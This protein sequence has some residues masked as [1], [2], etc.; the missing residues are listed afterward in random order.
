MERLLAYMIPVLG[1]LNL[2]S[3]VVSLGCA[4]R[5]GLST[6]WATIYILII[7]IIGSIIIYFLLTTSTGPTYP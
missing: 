7:I 3:S 2:D 6:F 4:R 5:S 1:L